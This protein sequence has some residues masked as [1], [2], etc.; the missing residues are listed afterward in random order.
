LRNG[1]SSNDAICSRGSI[2][3]SSIRR[4]SPSPAPVA[5]HGYSQDHRPDLRQMILAVVL[6]GE[7]RPVCSEMW[8]GN[9]AGVAGPLPV[10]ARS[11]G[12]RSDAS[13][14]SPIAA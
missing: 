2:W 4:A 3:C 6:Y 14:S 13:A 9:T 10:V 11:S 1:C 5:L 12:A 8:P 7:G